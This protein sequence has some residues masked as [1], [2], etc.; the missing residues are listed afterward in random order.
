MP[1][2]LYTP[3]YSAPPNPQ[4]PV[5]GIW[6]WVLMLWQCFYQATISPVP[7]S[8]F[9]TAKGE[10]KKEIGSRE[11]QGP[12]DEEKTLWRHKDNSP[13]KDHRV[14][15][16]LEPRLM[17]SV[18]QLQAVHGILAGPDEQNLFHMSQGKAHFRE[19]RNNTGHAQVNLRTE[20]C[21]SNSARRHRGSSR[22]GSGM[23]S[24]PFL[25]PFKRTYDECLCWTGLLQWIRSEKSLVL[26]ICW[27]RGRHI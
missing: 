8:V 14:R 11:K 10:S 9:R 20:N 4:P 19:G 23:K 27:K 25:L 13:E 26:S 1:V 3:T 16:G 2:D 17:R 6:P 18:E 12:S 21:P 7:W 15:A 24:R 22:V 5:L